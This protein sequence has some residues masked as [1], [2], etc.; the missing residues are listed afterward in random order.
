MVVTCLEPMSRA[1][2]FDH[3]AWIFSTNVNVSMDVGIPRIVH[4]GDLEGSCYLA[5]LR[6]DCLSMLTV[7]QSHY[8]LFRLPSA[9]GKKYSVSGSTPACM[10]CVCPIMGL[11]VD[12]SCFVLP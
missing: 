1:R 11:N 9:R 8:L 4:S 7:V 6:A 2:K 3:F 10:R 5:L 12:F